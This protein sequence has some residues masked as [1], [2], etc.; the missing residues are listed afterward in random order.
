MAGLS[1]QF[2]Q[3]AEFGRRMWVT[4]TNHW[5]S[6]EATVYTDWDGQELISLGNRL[7][8]FPKQANDVEEMELGRREWDTQWAYGDVEEGAACL[9]F[10][11]YCMDRFGH[12]AVFVTLE[13]LRFERDLHD[14]VSFEIRFE[15]AQ[16]DQF[17]AEVIEMGKTKQGTA[18]LEDTPY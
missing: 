15:P 5:F 3:P 14:R 4:A 7:K 6:A 1:I 13:N 12:L 10:N 16:F 2:I 11:F 9:V 18:T 8:G 17:I